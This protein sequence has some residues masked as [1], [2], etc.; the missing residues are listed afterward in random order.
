MN[1]RAILRSALVALATAAV[2]IP[3][4]L[5]A[6]MPVSPSILTFPDTASVRVE[7]RLAGAT[8]RAGEAVRGTIR[9]AASGDMLWSGELGR[10]AA[11]EGG[12]AGVV[13]TLRDLH[14]RLWSPSSPNLY[15]LAV[16]IGP[17]TASVR[18]GF[19]GVEQKDGR[20]ILNGKPIFLRGNAINP[21][22]RQIPETLDE[23]PG[24]VRDYLRY[25][26]GQGVNIIRLTRTSQAWLDGADEVGMMIFQGNYGRP[27]SAT[28]SRPPSDPFEESMRWYREDVL[29]PLVNHPS[30]VIYVLAN[31]QASDEIPYL[32]RGAAGIQD[33]LTRAY[34]NLREWDSTRLYIGNAGYGF[35]RSGDV[36]DIHRYWGWYYN[37]FLSFYTLRDP[38]VCWRT[39]RVQPITLSEN[40]GNYTGPNGGYNLVPNTKQPASQLNW[41][42][43]APWRE[44]PSRALAYQAWMAG[45]AIEITRRTREQNP[46]LAG[47]M[48]FSIL[49]HN[50]AG[51]D[52]FA[53]MGPKPI[54]TQYAISYQPV[55][56]S[57]ELWTPQVY[58]GSTLRPVAH[59]VND[60]ES[61]ENLS[62][63]SLRYRLE[64]ENGKV[65][66]EGRR[67]LG[68]VR[69]YDASSTP[70]AIE[71]PPTLGTG[72]YTLRGWVVR[73]GDTLSTNS[74]ALF[75]ARP[76]FAG[77][78]PAG[79]QVVLYDPIGTTRDAFRTAGIP[80]DGIRTPVGL[81]PARQTLVIGANAWDYQLAR[82]E[83]ELRA[84][85]DQG[86]RVILLRQE[87]G[88]FD[89]S[90]LPTPIEIQS[91]PLDH[92]L[93]FPPGRPY[94][95][96]MAVNPERTDHPVFDGIDR[97]RLFLWSD[98][99]AWNES[100]HGFPEVYPVTHGFVLTRPDALA[101]TAILADYGH[102]LSGVALAES[103]SGAGSIVISGFDL[104]DRAGIDPV[105]D[106]LLLNLV[107]YQ[108][109]AAPHHVH[110][111][112]ADPIV[113]GDY[114][115]EHGLVVGVYNG[116]LVNGVPRI[117]ADLRAS[118]PIRIDSI[119]GW[120]IAGGAGGWNTKPSIQYVAHGRR[121]FGPYG[122]TAGGSERLTDDAGPRGTGTVWLRVPAGTA[123]M[124]TQVWNPA[125]RALQIQ[126]TVNG[127][128][129]SY[130][131]PAGQ[132]VDL[133][134][135]LPGAATD[136]ALTFQGDRRLVLLRTAFRGPTPARDPVK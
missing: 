3:T 94:R 93:V 116:L 43:H 99:T 10:L 37:S 29:G 96:G 39:D 115:T 57:W 105:A 90:W 118:N 16:S 44:Q 125:Q 11:G 28:S 66:L 30:V 129:R 76:D 120:Q 12:G 117:P 48:P 80:F 9:D 59:L 52:S 34:L 124:S 91:E 107:R 134:T 24:F 35:G 136:L 128:A 26:K 126:I 51:I 102:G 13:T 65:A 62:G 86:G 87:P 74:T 114:E 112:V 23:D 61:G 33:F 83:N 77:T 121:P 78:V 97:D 55:L 15:R 45:Q 58:A 100:K 19:R 8:A 108:T 72:R 110:P 46:Y 127:I 20:V 122:F 56:L 85:V 21:P 22:E 131:I 103:F 4:S 63:L 14:P 132:T 79:R 42:G 71:L 109:G 32:S 82:F 81:D 75:V 17:D 7:V 130:T 104:V 98:F 88:R 106:R 49:F 31:E 69:Y 18:F 70:L 41:T 5:S 27:R 47:L 60:S 84:F 1:R 67:D 54:L 36:C 2:A 123:T 40:T 6:Q 101:S 133:D 68:D 38:D 92:S 95:N 89:S 53:E 50:W 64:D 25:M 111:L 119:E 73:G 135:R 113:W